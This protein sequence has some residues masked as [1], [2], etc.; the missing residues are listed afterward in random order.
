MRGLMLLPLLV[1]SAPAAEQSPETDV[2][3][4]FGELARLE[5]SQ[6]NTTVDAVRESD[7]RMRK[8]GPS[9]LRWG[10][11]AIPALVAVARDKKMPPKTRLMAVSV[12]GL[13]RDPAAFRPLSEM[14]EDPSL[15]DALRSEAALGLGGAGVSKAAER[16]AFCGALADEELPP[17]A[18]HEALASASRLGCDD[19]RLLERRARR[20]GSKP[21][22]RDAAKAR[23]LITALAVTPTTEAGA[24][25]WRLYDFYPSQSSLRGAV[26]AAQLSDE[27]RLKTLP[28]GEGRALAAL[29]SESGNPENAALAAR[30]AARA[31]TP[32]CARALIRMLKHVE[33]AVLA[34]AAE[35]LAA[36]KA[37]EAKPELAAL[38]DGAHADPRFAPK[39]GRPDPA[40]QLGRL[41]AALRSL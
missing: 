20:L 32:A 24:A 37:K 41:Q 29:S 31:G 26:L 19:V 35:G 25:L 9:V 38:V 21:K 34:E 11:K 8:L 7:E 4:I 17:L 22:K 23:L 10:H 13:T 36:L 28:D 33:P 3:A 39:P 27:G 16:R 30:L 6:F 1:C 14:L 2:A 12:I 5:R 40:V 18:L 15:S